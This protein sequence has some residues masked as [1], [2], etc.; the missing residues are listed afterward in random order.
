MF[1]KTIGG[2]LTL[3]LAFGFIFSMPDISRVSILALKK[4]GPAKPG[5]PHFTP[6]PSWPLGPHFTPGPSQQPG[7]NPPNL[8]PPHC[9]PGPNEPLGPHFTP[10]QSHLTSLRLRT[11]N[12]NHFE[13]GCAEFPPDEETPS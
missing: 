7:P 11:Q 5:G 12:F 9:P 6:G 8:T 3:V 1:N 13:G 2:L 4:P 10:G